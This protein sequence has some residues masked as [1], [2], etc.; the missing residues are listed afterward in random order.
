[1]VRQTSV[2]PGLEDTESAVRDASQRNSVI[3]S[4]PLKQQTKMV[5]KALSLG[6]EGGIEE[7][8]RFMFKARRDGKRGGE[9]L[10]SEFNLITLVLIRRF[11]SPA[12]LWYHNLT[13]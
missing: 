7:V 3:S 5:R 8:R 10:L 12:T 1:M 6:S 13:A 4:L 2:L 11:D 9:I